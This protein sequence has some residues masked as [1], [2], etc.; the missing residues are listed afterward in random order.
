M[1]QR[2]VK[3]FQTLFQRA[4]STSIQDCEIA[5]KLPLEQTEDREYGCGHQSA[6]PS[7]GDLSMFAYVSRVN[8]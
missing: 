8:S 5:K 2:A 3:L 7:R 1:H 4:K 6:S